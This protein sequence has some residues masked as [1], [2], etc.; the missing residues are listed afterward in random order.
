MLESIGYEPE[1]ATWAV[2][3]DATL[4]RVVRVDRGLASVLTEDGPRRVSYGAQLLAEI[5]VDPS[6]AP[7]V[8]D[9]CVLR[10]WPDRR[11]T[12]ERLLPRRTAVERATAGKASHSQVLCTNVDLVAAVI[13]LHPTPVLSKLERLLALAWGSGAEPLVVLTKTDLVGDADLVAQDVRDRA[14]KAE[15]VLTST[16][17]GEGVDRLRD[18]LAGRRTLA[19]IGT[20]GHGKSSLTNALVGADAL[21]TREI[22]A[23]GRG[24][25]TSV[26]RELVLVPG[27]GAVIDTPGLRGV[28]LVDAGEGL[29]GAFAEIDAL[30]GGCRFA[31]CAHLYEPGCA[32]QQALAGG[33]LPM[34]RF[35]SWQRL[36]REAARLASRKDA[37]LLGVR[38][39]VGRIRSRES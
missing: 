13:G 18:R 37:R 8:G 39:R 38:S 15:I 1:M 30:A 6:E 27:G 19:L 26:R 21:T 28:G 23:D 29:A 24:R 34:R 5:A 17:T 10:E 25:H 14:P 35:E 31:D 4:G 7:S 12:V 32:V 9:W 2:A 36:R 33:V 22:R 11:T 3:A 20:S 16:I